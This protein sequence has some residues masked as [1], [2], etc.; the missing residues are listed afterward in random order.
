MA[1]SKARTS[2]WSE[3]E[4]SSCGAAA[5][6]CPRKLPAEIKTGTMSKIRKIP[7]ANPPGARLL[8]LPL[9]ANFD[10]RVLA[11]NTF[12][13][14]RF[15]RY[16]PVY[17]DNHTPSS[18]REKSSRR[19]VKTHV[20]YDGE[21]L[22]PFGDEEAF[23]AW[24]NGCTVRGEV[25]ST[26]SPLS[27]QTLSNSYLKSQQIMQKLGS[28]FDFA[29]YESH[30]KGLILKILPRLHPQGCGPG[31]HL[32]KDETTSSSSG[33]T[34]DQRVL[35][36]ESDNFLDIALSHREGNLHLSQAGG[37]LLQRGSCHGDLPAFGVLSY[38]HSGHGPRRSGQA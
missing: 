3:E 10:S 36:P 25:P 28:D 27:R 18:N 35:P 7:T 37:A 8:Q 19:A 6:V 13:A 16:P 20:Y 34:T 14:K 33:G 5:A 24:N 2:C 23:C 26:S 29:L 32:Q 12:F 22:G 15:I 21:D 4:N 11:A 30:E 38:I 9:R 31:I 17:S 1:Q